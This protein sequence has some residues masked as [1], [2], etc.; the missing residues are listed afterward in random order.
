M[1][2]SRCCVARPGSPDAWRQHIAHTHNR[3]GPPEILPAPSPSAATAP[4][5]TVSTAISASASPVAS[6]ASGMLGLG[7]RLVYVER[8]SAHL[9]AI[10]PSNGLFSILVTGHF[11]EAEP[12]R[13]PGIAVRH[14][15][16]PVDLPERFKHLPQFIFRC[17]KAQ[18][19]HEDILQA[20]ASALSC[21]SASS[22]RRTGRSGTPS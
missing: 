10:Q 3:W 7:A 19:P 21:R 5:A 13:S 1:W 16:Y 17:V 6:A 15:A 20:S 4:P 9:R 14:D 22:M 2:L 18:V 12:P 8:A 11:Y